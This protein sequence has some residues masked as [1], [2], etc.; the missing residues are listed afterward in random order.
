MFSLKEISRAK[1]GMYS[2][3]S[4][5]FGLTFPFAQWVYRNPLELR[6]FIPEV[7]LYAVV[8]FLLL[9]VIDNLSRKAALVISEPSEK[10]QQKNSSTLPLA[11]QSEQDERRSPPRFW[12]RV[13]ASLT[14]DRKLCLLLFGVLAVVYFLNFL[15]YYPGCGT[16]DSDVAINQA[17]GYE[18]YSS[19]M[20]PFHT[21]IVSIILHIGLLVSDLEGALALFSTIQLLVCAAVYSYFLSWLK[22]KG[23]PSWAFTLCLLFFALNPIIARFAVTMWKDI[24]FSLSILLLVTLLFDIAQS[25]GALLR[26]RRALIKLLVICFCV[27]FFRKNGLIIVGGVALFLLF[28]LRPQKAPAISLFLLLIASSVIQGPVFAAIGIKP[29]HFVET[30]ALPMQQMGNL[31]YM[32]RPL[33]EEQATLMNEIIPENTLREVYRYYSP[34]SMKYSG[35]FDHDYL[36][37]HKGEFLLTWLQLMSAYPRDYLQAWGSLNYGYWYVGSSGWIV[38][39]AGFARQEARNLLF[40]R[41]G[42]TW[43]NT[44]LDTQYEDIRNYPLTYPLFNL[45]CLIWMTLASALLCSNK[46]SRW[47]LVCLLPA[48]LLIFTMLVSAP[49]AEFRYIF[50]LHLSLPLTLAL[51]FLKRQAQSD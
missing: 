12:P 15:M 16:A 2:L 3:F 39:D 49:T 30:V 33:S 7:P 10:E 19:W 24:P 32:D 21:F 25:R 35:S 1:L 29:D 26:N 28:W 43:A 48:L 50:A 42:F 38:A 37:S 44:G 31:V 8:A 9:L 36:D 20:P 11:E 23:I 46:N 47:K 41:T 18:Q 13:K 45:G 4:L 17:L 22:R 40:E 34:D 14:P 27:L 5:L 6:M 51:P